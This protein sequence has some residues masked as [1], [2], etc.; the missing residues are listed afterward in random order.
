MMEMQR[1]GNIYILDGNIFLGSRETC[2]Y[3]CGFSGSKYLRRLDP[4]KCLMPGGKTTDGQ[5][6]SEQVQDHPRLLSAK[7]RCSKE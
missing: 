1:D 6:S 5:A 7:P 2:Y 3:S 4:E